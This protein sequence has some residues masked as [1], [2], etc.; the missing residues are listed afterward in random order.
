[1]I[2]LP[3]D[4]I[5][6]EV[7]RQAVRVLEWFGAHRGLDCEIRFADFGAEA[8]H[9]TGTF[10]REDV[11]AD[12]KTADVILFGAIG[13]MSAQDRVPPE[14]RRQWGLLRVRRE[15]EVFANL[16]RA[17]GLEGA[18]QLHTSENEG[19]ENLPDSQVAN[20]NETTSHW[21]KVSAKEDGAFTVTNGRTGATKVFAARPKP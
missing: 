17:P 19:A 15:L 9:R 7:I 6:P 4:G 11:L 21:I 13:G 16:R 10:L 3:G 12:M 5:G 20:L 14:V 1:M 18:W 2:V 8:W